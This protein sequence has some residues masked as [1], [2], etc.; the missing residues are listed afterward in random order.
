MTTTP[1]LT[2]EMIPRP[3]HRKSLSCLLKRKLWNV[4]GRSVRARAEGRCEICGDESTRLDC[5]EVWSYDDERRVARLVGLKAICSACHLS[6]HMGRATSIG[7]QDK[8][9][10]HLMD[11]NGW[12]SQ[13]AL[14]H[15]GRAMHEWVMRSKHAWVLD[16]SGLPS[17]VQSLEAEDRIA[18]LA[19]RPA[20]KFMED[21]LGPYHPRGSYEV[22]RLRP[23]ATARQGSGPRS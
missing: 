3:L 20:V 6:T 8:A 19:A 1:L 21:K 12:T 16:V 17:I 2:I 11:V 23:S 18:A 5:H 13:Q 14:P 7:R 22:P 10:A 4:I 9:I 15:V